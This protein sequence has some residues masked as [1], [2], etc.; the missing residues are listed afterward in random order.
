MGA[1]PGNWIHDTEKLPF[2]PRR[3]RNARKIAYDKS[4]QQRRAGAVF[5]H[6]VFETG[7]IGPDL[8]KELNVAAI[9]NKM[10]HVNSAIEKVGLANCERQPT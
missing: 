10:G 2:G 9:Q 6:G 1:N 3:V 7:E 5:Y 8:A 4:N